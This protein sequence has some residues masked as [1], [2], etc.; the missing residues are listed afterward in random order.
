LFLKTSN[1]KITKNSV[2]H[3]SCY[4]VSEPGYELTY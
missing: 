1:V 2:S 3:N 4:A